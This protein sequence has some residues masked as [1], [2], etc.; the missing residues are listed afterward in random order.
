[1]PGFV[2]FGLTVTA[3]PA[4]QFNSAIEAG[5]ESTIA[6]SLN[7]L[8]LTR[9][10]A[11]DVLVTSVSF[12][13]LWDRLVVILRCSYYLVCSA[14]AGRLVLKSALAVSRGAP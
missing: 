7:G 13:L 2:A 12:K 6:T 11:S 4:S 3:V 5:V 10:T 14:V 1:M 9:I 8:T